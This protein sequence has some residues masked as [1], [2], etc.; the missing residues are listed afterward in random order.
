MQFMLD[1]FE[2][3]DEPAAGT[4]RGYPKEFIID[5]FRCLRRQ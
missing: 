1:I 4:D 3:R 5:A 2:F